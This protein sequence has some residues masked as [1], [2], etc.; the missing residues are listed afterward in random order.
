MSRDNT[1]TK[2]Y[3][4][5]VEVDII[6]KVTDFSSTIYIFAYKLYSTFWKSHGGK[7]K[8]FIQNL[9]KSYGLL[10]LLK[11]SKQ[12]LFSRDL[13]L[14]ECCIS[15]VIFEFRNLAAILFSSL[16]KFLEIP[17]VHV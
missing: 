12:K 3:F 15:H 6:L 16:K 7:K 4:L 9:R 11:I 5:S 8:Y 2:C 17:G 1:S 14:L 13:N 10:L